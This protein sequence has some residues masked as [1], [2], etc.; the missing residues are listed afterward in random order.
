M[1]YYLSYFNY[2]R[3]AETDV[4][5]KTGVQEE[6]I[7]SN[8]IVEKVAY[9]GAIHLQDIKWERLEEPGDIHGAWMVA[10]AELQL[11]LCPTESLEVKEITHHRAMME[12]LGH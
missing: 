8:K 9:V 12:E 6:Y 5:V 3:H 10:S 4:H 1:A 11:Y 7:S 2:I